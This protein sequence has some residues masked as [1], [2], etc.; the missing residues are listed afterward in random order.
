MS[1]LVNNV[2][3]IT[4]YRIFSRMYFYL[5]IIFPF[6][7]VSGHGVETIELLLALYGIAVTF[8]I[9]LSKKITSF[10]GHKNA[11]ILGELFKITG[12]LLF[13]LCAQKTSVLCL[14]QITMGI[15]YSLIVGNDTVIL[16]QSFG[17]NATAEYQIAQAKTNSYMF[18]ALL[19][20]G[21][22][23]AFL[24]AHSPILVMW[25]SIG[26][27]ILSVASILTMHYIKQDRVMPHS[28]ISLPVMKEAL[29]YYFIIRGLVLAVFVGVLPYFFFLLMHTTMVWFGVILSSFTLCGFLSS[30]YLTHRFKKISITTL[31]IGSII[32]IAFAFLCLLFGN[33]YI[34]AVTTILLG[35]LSGCVRPVT[36][37]NIDGKRFN[38]EKTLNKAEFYYGIF[39]AF[40]LVMAA[41]FFKYSTFNTY[42]YFL[43]GICVLSSLFIYFTNQGD[44]P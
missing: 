21:L 25:L 22:V 24:F 3:A 13:I 4:A 28:V 15:G 31:S 5:P 2:R 18:I 41:L 36:V 1:N 39:N 43:V 9:G 37:A 27:A 11:L 44:T 35:L 23:G 10:I 29:R 20:S 40:I 38:V 26:A 8:F 30:K 16:Q 17:E 12:L 6:F 33:M 34:G 42:I 19:L 7:Y 14:A 32:V